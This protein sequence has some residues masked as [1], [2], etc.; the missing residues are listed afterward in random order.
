MSQRGFLHLLDQGHA[1]S[2]EAPT[3]WDVDF[4]TAVSQ[5]EM[6]DRELPG[7]YHRLRF[8]RCRRRRAR[9]R[10]RRRGPSCWPPAWRSW[11]IPTTRR[12]RPLFG[13]EV[14]TPLFG[15]AVPVLAHELADPEKGSGVAMICTFGDITDVT[16]W[17]DLGSAHPDDRRAQRS[18]PT[19]RLG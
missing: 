13:T 9:W 14:I 8:A 15:V 3:Q 17:R 16:W 5:A 10:S 7:A 18:A 4:Q 1:Y 11:P 6:E 2:A 19:G 12:Y